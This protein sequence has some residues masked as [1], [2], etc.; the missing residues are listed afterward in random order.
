MI[1]ITRSLAPV[2]L[3]IS[4]VSRLTAEFCA[5]KDN[6]V[7]NRADIRTCLLKMSN[8]KCSYCEA[9]IDEQS[10]YMEVEH[11]KN[12][13]LYPLLVVEWSNLLSSCKH[14]N[15]SKG[16]HDVSAMPIVDPTTMDPRDHLLISNYRFFGKTQVGEWTKD[17]LDLND[18]K[19]NVVHR[20]KVGEIIMEASYEL[21]QICTEYSCDKNTRNKN[22]MLRKIRSLMHEALPSSQYSAIS[23]TIIVNNSHFISAKSYILS[24][25][26]WDVELDMLYN[27]IMKIA[28]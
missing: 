27:E 18:G 25:G 3:D 15:T 1:K 14:C 10:Q 7:W 9:I 17:V 26:F 6:R 21:E 12:K 16:K 28:Y 20:F 8:N 23:S 13:T 22:R 24:V 2:T 11:F 19:R 5:D 4:T